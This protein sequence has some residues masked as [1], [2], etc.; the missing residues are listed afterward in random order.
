[1]TNGCDEIMSGYW[2]WMLMSGS[3]GTRV[4]KDSRKGAEVVI[5]R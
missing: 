1:M 5:K 4:V 3:A 2:R